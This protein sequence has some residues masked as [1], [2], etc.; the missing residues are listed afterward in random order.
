VLTYWKGLKPAGKA[1]FAFGSYGWAKGAT[2]DVEAYL[3]EMKFD[4]L[5]E[6]LCSQF[7]PDAATL[8]ECRAAGR[9]LAGH[10]AQAF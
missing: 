1:G 8:E 6:P 7:A 5:R 2:R 10:A 9:L 4:L 3:K